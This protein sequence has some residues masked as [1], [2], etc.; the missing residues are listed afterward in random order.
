MLYMAINGIAPNYIKALV[1][2]YVLQSYL[3][4]ANDNLFSFHYGD[5]T[6]MVAV[7]TM[8]NKLPIVINLSRNVNIFKKNQK[9]SF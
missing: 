3:R 2:P 9:T 7:P 5:L 1:T 8:W 6:F 4:S